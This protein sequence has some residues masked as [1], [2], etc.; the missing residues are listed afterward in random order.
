MQNKF[1]IATDFLNLD[2]N[3]SNATRL[4][5]KTDAIIKNYY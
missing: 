4:H 1:D 3:R 2:K 5:Q